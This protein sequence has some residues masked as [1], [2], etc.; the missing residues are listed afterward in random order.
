MFTPMPS[1]YNA[2]NDFANSPRVQLSDN[3]QKLLGKTD[4]ETVGATLA[5]PVDSENSY[6]QQIAN[7]ANSPVTVTVTMQLPA[8]TMPQVLDRTTPQD[9]SLVP[10][11]TTLRHLITNLRGVLFTDRQPEV[12]LP[13]NTLLQHLHAII[14]GR[15]QEKQAH[16]HWF[17]APALHTYKPNAYNASVLEYARLRRYA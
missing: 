13:T 17:T 15:R 1:A 5:S 12:E 10:G 2:L 4:N 8:V 16:S 14:I 3:L 7:W 11:A 6:E 9:D